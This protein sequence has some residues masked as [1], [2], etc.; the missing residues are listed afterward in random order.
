MAVLADISVDWRQTPRLITVAAPR[1]AVSVQD[2]YDTLRDLE[3][4]PVNLGYNS[5]IS[6]GGKEPLGAGQSVGI[7]ASLLNAVIKFEDRGVATVCKVEGGNI[8]AFDIDGLQVDPVVYS[9]NVLAFIAQS[10]SATINDVSLT[11]RL[12]HLIAAQ[13][14]THSPYGDFFYWDPVNGNDTHDGLLPET[15]RAT[16]ASI[17]DNLCSGYTRD[18]VVLLARDL[19]GSTIINERLIITKNHVLLHGPGRFACIRGLDDAADTIVIDGAIGV[20][21]DSV[22]VQTG[23]GPIARNAVHVTNGSNHTK[24]SN[25]YMDVR[26]GEYITG[27]AVVIDGGT[28]HIIDNLFIEGPAG[29]G[30]KIADSHATRIERCKILG[31]GVSGI[32]I[33]STTPG[34]TTNVTLNDNVIQQATVFDVVIDAGVESTAIRFLNDVTDASSILDN[35]T[36]TQWERLNQANFSA[37]R[38]WEEIGGAHLTPGTVGFNAAAMSYMGAIN[39][40]TGNGSAGTEFGTNGTVGNPVN[41]L[42]D[43]A[44]LDAILKSRT[45]RLR[46]NI[47]LLS[48][49]DDWTFL[50]TGTETNIAFNGQDVQ[51]SFFDGC[52]LSGDA[53]N[54]HIHAHD[55]TL[56]GLTNFSGIFGNC[57]LRNSLSLAAA[58]T[59]FS[60]CVSYVPGGGTPSLDVQGAGRSFHFRAYS[61]GIEIRNMSDAGNAGSVELI[62]GQ[63]VLAATCTNTVPDNALAIRGTGKLTNLGTIVPNTDSLLNNASLQTPEIIQ[64]WTRAVSG[65]SKM[66]AMVA[67]E[68]GGQVISLPGTATLDVTVRDSSGVAVIT[69]AGIAPNLAGY[70]ELTEDPFTPSA[71]V[72]LASFATITNGTDVYTG[73]TPISFP[74][75]S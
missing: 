46:G 28:H 20:E 68:L 19:S 67:L 25:I 27:D 61:G 63:V 59:M 16:F 57:R 21:I 44:A 54:S 39:I 49:H 33:S 5:I 66:K 69:Q 74:E 15:A 12:Q 48:A 3:D 70:F 71:G 18:T 41:N 8:V 13:D 11:Q 22:R 73:L 60:H 4:E 6:A 10:S 23:P 56:D 64:S 37:F 45:Y 32:Q 7:T 31:P 75:F 62:A 17:H 50:G 35:G 72:N 34:D 42:A 14:E 30:I 29:N 38:T 52:E 53:A 36:D 58:T 26:P 47:T 40:D 51:D 1:T 24:L 2:L 9:I 55:C 65:G 43:A